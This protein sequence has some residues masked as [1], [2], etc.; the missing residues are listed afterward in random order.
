M[1]GAPRERSSIKFPY[2]ALSEAEQVA[3]AV[4]QHGLDC[5][6]DQLAAVM[7]QNM[8]GAFRN[9]VAT[10][11]TFGAVETSRGRVTL[12][13][14]GQRLVDPQTQADARVEAFL[15]VPLYEQVYESF[16]G[17]RL[18]ADQGL[19]AAI[20]K[21][22]VSPKQAP[23]A[24]QAMNRSAEQAGF[25]LHGRD[26]LV[27]PPRQAATVTEVRQ[28]S[29]GDIG[30]GM[31]SGEQIAGFVSDPLIVGLWKRL[32][33]PEKGT[34]TPEQQEAWLNAARVNL[35]LLYGGVPSGR[36]ETPV[37]PSIT[38]RAEREA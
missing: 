16:R 3:G 29:D 9:K 7:G 4:W 24:R 33:D 32:P 14:L 28:V 20:V 27:E 36:A 38:N 35:Q 26:R 5:A 31:D 12:T 6:I 18:P 23:K 2:G 1:V 37:P 30:R 11:V 25:F 17:R 21:F 22:G 15:Q 19:E 34:F 13:D 8:S 10:A